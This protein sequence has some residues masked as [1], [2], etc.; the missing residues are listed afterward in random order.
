MNQGAGDLE[1]T[2]LTLPGDEH[3]CESNC[4]N[5]ELTTNSLRAHL[6]SHH[7]TS[8]HTL[9]RR[10]SSSEELVASRYHGDAPI[11]TSSVVADVTDSE[12]EAEEMTSLLPREPT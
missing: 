4:S 6:Y 3:T 7:S 12:S 8:T 10:T 1:L 2:E 5:L 9:S 11:V